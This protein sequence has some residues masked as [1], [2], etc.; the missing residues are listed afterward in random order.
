MRLSFQP[1]AKKTRS[2][3]N[4]PDVWS[5]VAMRKHPPNAVQYTPNPGGSVKGRKC[6]LANL[7][8]LRAPANFAA[9]ASESNQKK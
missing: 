7:R 6:F 2:G 4:Q 1:A 9:E 5:G 3:A 8:S